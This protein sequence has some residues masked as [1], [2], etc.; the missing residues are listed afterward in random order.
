MTPYWVQYARDSQQEFS[1]LSVGFGANVGENVL[2]YKVW[3]YNVFDVTFF[4]FTSTTAQIQNLEIGDP[5]WEPSPSDATKFDMGQYAFANYYHFIDW[6]RQWATM[7][8]SLWMKMQ[9]KCSQKFLIAL[10]GEAEFPAVVEKDS[11]QRVYVVESQTT[12]YVHLTNVG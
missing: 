5:K 7:T 2:V 8:G 6:R 4:G 12:K 10:S 9:V 3:Q 11:H 1:A